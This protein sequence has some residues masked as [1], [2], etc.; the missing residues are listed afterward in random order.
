MASGHPYKVDMTSNV[1]LI[2]SQVKGEPK[3]RNK[4]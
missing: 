2:V 4:L 3:E 1:Q